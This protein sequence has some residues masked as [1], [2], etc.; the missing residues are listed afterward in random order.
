MSVQKISIDDH[1]AVWPA[2]TVV[3]GDVSWGNVELA[4]GPVVVVILIGRILVKHRVA[5]KDKFSKLHPPPY[6]SSQSDGYH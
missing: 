5:V 4:I 1:D 2:M 6:R 3:G